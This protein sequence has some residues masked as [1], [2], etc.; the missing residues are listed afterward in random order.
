M[1]RN[2][3]LILIHLLCGALAVTAKPL[4]RDTNLFLIPMPQQASI[5]DGTYHLDIP[6]QII[7]PSEKAAFAAKQIDAE[8]KA[9][10]KSL[11]ASKVKENSIVFSLLNPASVLEGV[12][13]EEIALLSAHREEGYLLQVHPHQIT[14]AAF[15]DTGLF[16]GAQTLK[17]LIR[18]NR[19][20]DVIPC[21]QILDW[22]ALRYRG[23]MDDISRGPIPSID[24]LKK[25]IQELS[26]YKLNCL[27]L[28]TEHVFRLNRYPDIA[29]ADGLTAA[30]LKELERFAW[31]Y[32]IEIIGNQQAFGHAEK[33]LSIPYYRDMGENSWVLSPSVDKTYEFLRNVM[34]EVAPAY[35]SS[36]FNINCDEVYGL[37]EGP[38]KK[39]VDSIGKE[40]VYAYHIHQV[41][42][43]LETYHKRIMMW[44]DIAVD[45]PEII[46]QL[47]KDLIILS[48]G[49]DG[50]ASFDNAILPF[51]KTGF[52]FMVAPG[53]SCWSQV[54][55]DMGNAV[56]NIA[57]YVR[58]G[59]RLGAMGMLNTC[60]DDDG[61]NLFNANWHGLIWG[62]EMGWQ[63]TSIPAGKE[64]ELER[65]ERLHHFNQS[66]DRLFFGSDL[67]VVETLFGFDSLRHMP[68]RGLLQDG[69]IWNNLLDFNPE[70]TGPE[71]LLRNQKLVADADSLE[72][73][74]AHL[75]PLIPREAE[76]MDLALF[77]ARRVAFTGLK[78][79]LR[80][81]IYLAFQSGRA[82][83]I[84]AAKL[85][86]DSLM[87]SLESLK[88]D[89]IPLWQRENRNWWLDKVL[90]KY[91]QLAE[92]LRNL[93]KQV[94]IEPV[95]A[96]S[97]GKREI[98]LRTVFGGQPI[99]YSTDGS[100]VDR[101]ARRYEHPFFISGTSPIRARVIGD[102]QSFPIREQMVGV[103]KGIGRIMRLNSHYSR[104]NPAYAAGGDM[105]LADG[106]RGSEDFADGH[107]QG[108]QGA[109]L[110][111]VFDFGQP[112]DIHQLNARFL[113]N[114]HSWILMPE[115]VQY[116][117][118]EDGIHFKLLSEALNP[119][120]PK[121]EGTVLHTFS[122]GPVQVTARYLRVI[123]K[124][125][126][127]L[128]AWHHAAGGEAYI[129]SDEVE[130]N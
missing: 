12:S 95:N 5:L 16:Y 24:Y 48:W 57:N 92:Q 53:V 4:M 21:V 61:E 93:D 108:Y 17:Q 66:M 69:A 98:R 85:F 88:W 37:G 101:S 27:T 56:I 102:G 68:I 34:A 36:L 59:A 75:Q 26:E 112:T 8:I 20:E 87:I 44:G 109:D 119:V 81:L 125:P 120:D 118:S 51:Q 121:A 89:Y 63:P 60:W 122:S 6:F 25:V 3:L 106:L 15:T 41:A 79:Q 124:N 113:Q 50:A 9:V 19:K 97:D 45:H 18:G 99:Y 86:S 62:A 52:D 67:P 117:T 7:D 115:R 105:G 31:D 13:A 91:D 107:W 129:F 43:M 82:E 42:A 96:L 65:S 78:N 103:H 110:D 54:W 39:M 70:N 23:W 22:P 55:P 111:V 76:Q 38:S 73:I 83:D 94:F 40:G 1:C 126:G 74:I 77:A 28:Y 58:D 49:Y 128:P 11:P 127:K 33:T 100:P 116:F 29:P 84:A 35:Q 114:E 72:R 71:A 130:V 32:H 123:G 2:H 30:Q 46:S 47:P 14:I 90:A 80:C 64:A 10:L 104:Y